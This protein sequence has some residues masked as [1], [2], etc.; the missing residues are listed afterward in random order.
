MLIV[1]SNAECVPFSFIF[2]A[3][4][5][6]KCEGLYD[7]TKEQEREIEGFMTSCKTYLQEVEH[8]RCEGSTPSRT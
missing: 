7:I 6:K 4:Y 2:D 8:R 1:E 5:E 3:P